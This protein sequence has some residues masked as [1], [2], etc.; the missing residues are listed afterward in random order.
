MA[1]HHARHFRQGDYEPPAQ[2]S[3]LDVLP[4]FS[5]LPEGL[6]RAIV[7]NEGDWLRMQT[8][9]ESELRTYSDD[10]AAHWRSQ[11]FRVFG[12]RTQPEAQLLKTP[13]QP[14]KPRKAPPPASVVA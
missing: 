6:Q 3:K 12:M 5:Q 8:A 2:P 9:L 4:G 14:K 10:L 7:H 11:I 13:E 1:L